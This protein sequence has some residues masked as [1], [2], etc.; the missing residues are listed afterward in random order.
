MSQLTPT[1]LKVTE[2]KVKAYAA[3][4]GD[5][6]PLH[7]D[8]E[9]ARTTF[10]G[11]RIAHG[12]LSLN[13]LWQSIAATCGLENLGHRKLDIRFV[14]PVYLG[15][16]VTAGSA[17]AADDDGRLQVWVKNQHGEPVI[18]GWLGDAA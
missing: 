9:F 13:V 18:S 7:L 1:S 3:L 17:D 5:F 8:E 14:K 4:S 12:T 2:S 11:T 15:D 6:N 10:H 16:T